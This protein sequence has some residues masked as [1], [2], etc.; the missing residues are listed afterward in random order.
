MIKKISYC[1]T[2]MAQQLASL[3][4][5]IFGTAWN[6]ELIKQ[7]INKSLLVNLKR[8]HNDKKNNDTRIRKHRN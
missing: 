7:K 2:D 1:N 4:K 8:Q 5:E 3:E 6:N